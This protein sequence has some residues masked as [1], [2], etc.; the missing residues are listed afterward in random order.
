VPTHEPTTH[1]D[2]P[3][4]AARDQVSFGIPSEPV[5]TIV[6]ATPRPGQLRGSLRLACSSSR[7]LIVAPSGVPEERDLLH[8]L[9]I[10]QLRRGRYISNKGLQ[11]R[12]R[13]RKY[14]RRLLIISATL[15]CG[16]LTLG[17]LPSAQAGGKVYRCF[18][19]KATI[20]G[21][22]GD[23]DLVGTARPDVIAALG[24]GDWVNAGGGDDLICGGPGDDWSWYYG[25]ESGGAAGL[26]GGAGN[27]WIRGSTGRDDVNGDDI[28]GPPGADVLYGGWGSDRVVDNLSW[29][30]YLVPEPL[31]G[32]DDVLFG[33]PGN[34][35]VTATG[36]DDYVSAGPGND[37]LGRAWWD[38]DDGDD[39]R[40]HGSDAY[41]GGDGDDRI[42]TI[43][44]VRGNDAINAGTGTD[45]CS[46]DEGDALASC[47]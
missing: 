41:T 14:F 40:D 47:E 19:V 25:P 13:M 4:S 44:D 12:N 22:P 16:V 26:Y 23:D 42:H 24:G 17:T 32:S 6:L 20:V 2:G 28:N 29:H 38:D 31:P 21:T 5:V 45:T 46:A 3:R 39:L 9:L 7:H 27:D 11:M 30:E 36:G 1:A 10:D 33:G 18:G 8:K 15:S 35:V 43:D 37:L 34:D